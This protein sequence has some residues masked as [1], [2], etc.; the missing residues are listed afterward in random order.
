MKNENDDDDNS[1]DD[2][3]DE[4]IIWETTADH[5]AAKIVGSVGSLSLDW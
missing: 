4:V 1:S 3:D 2:D 5:K